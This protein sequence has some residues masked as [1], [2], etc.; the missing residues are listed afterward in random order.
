MGCALANKFLNKLQKHLHFQ[1]FSRPASLI[2][3]GISYYEKFPTGKMCRA[4]GTEFFYAINYALEIFQRHV[5]LA[6]SPALHRWCA[7]AYIT[8]FLSLTLY[9][10]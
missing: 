1:W 5:F 6:L 7:Y 3:G 8:D 10:G 2:I 9:R 4:R